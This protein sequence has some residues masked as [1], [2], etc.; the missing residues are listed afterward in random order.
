[1]ATNKHKGNDKKAAELVKKLVALHTSKK[2]GPYIS[3]IRFPHFKNIKKR[4]RVDLDFPVTALVGPNGCG[5]TSALHALYGAPKGKSTSDYWF[6]TDVD[7]IKEGHGQP[8]RFIYGHWLSGQ[9]DPVETRKAR[10]GKSRKRKPGYF[11]PTKAT[12]GDGMDTSPFPSTGSTPGQS[13]DRWNPVER[14]ILYINFRSELSA[15]DEFLFFGRS[16]MTKTLRNKQERLQ[17][18]AKRLNKAF[19]EGCQSKKLYG[20]RVVHEN[21]H[22]S[23]R[24][25]EA[26][27]DILGKQYDEAQLV[28]HD[29]YGG[30]TGLSIRFKTN[31]ATY[32]EAFAGS[33]ELAVAS[34]VIQLCSAK[35]HS[36]ILLDEPEVSLHPGAQER[37]V[38]FLM[39]EVLHHKHQVVFTT[40]SPGLI[41]LL[42]PEAIKVFYETDD[43]SFNVVN[44]AHPYTAFRRLGALIPDRIR[45]LVED[46]LA[47]NVVDIALLG[48]T[49]DERG[50][51]DVEYLP[52][53]S[54]TY[55]CQRVPTLMHQAGNTYLLLDGDQ[56]PED[57]YP[58]PDTIPE[59]ENETLITQIQTLTGCGKV[60]L[61]AD[62]GDDEETKKKLFMLQRKYLEFLHNKVHFLPRSC[63]EEIVLRAINSDAAP[64]TSLA[65]KSSLA[66]LVRKKMGGDS[67]EEIDN[68]AKVILSQ[69]RMENED[70][71]VT[72]ELLRGFLRSMR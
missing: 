55:L 40:H 44:A 18:D 11:E 65:A 13:K 58:A 28:Q 52:G 37:L 21:R 69:G 66:K 16:P 36:L 12:V 71:K 62:G 42:P 64:A 47:R 60:H 39:Q 53:G 22:L 20:K 30:K 25:L 45:I 67:S 26:V 61:G 34:L 63:P 46:R 56:S 50:L 29:Y 57:G 4:A 68:Y 32:S 7:P 6:A 48:L 27:C 5:K 33:G 17:R 14:P 1:M 38:L 51:F 23:G 43:G 31:H 72:E 9:G 35:K 8:N 41:N 10:V 49:D 54:K 15:F 19:E 3:H 24:E 59:S 70:I 2:L